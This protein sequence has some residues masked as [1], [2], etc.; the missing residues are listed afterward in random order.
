MI[1]HQHF[2]VMVMELPL[3]SKLICELFFMYLGICVQWDHVIGLNI[4]GAL[5]VHSEP[6]FFK[7]VIFKALMRHPDPTK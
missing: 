7:H 3:R 4:F 5:Q 6:N 1:R 2:S